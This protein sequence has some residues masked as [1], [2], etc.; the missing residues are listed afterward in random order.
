M[1]ICLGKG[2]PNFGHVGLH[3]YSINIKKMKR[4]FLP[5]L[6]VSLFSGCG[7]V[8]NAGTA[9]NYDDAYFVPSDI[10]KSQVYGK[11]DPNMFSLQNSTAM[12]ENRRTRSYGQSY[13]DR[14]RNFGGSTFTPSYRP[15]LM[16]TPFGTSM[17]YMP[18]GY[19]PY[20]MYG[21]PFAMGYGYNPYMY[22]PY[23]YDPYM[24]NPYYNPGWCYWNQY[25]SPYNQIYWGSNSIGGSSGS[26]SS[27]GGNRNAKPVPTYTYPSQRRGGYNSTLPSSGQS[28]RVGSGNT[29]SGNSS[30]STS[31]GS[32]YR[33]S[34]SNS[35]SGSSGGTYTRPSS[36]GSSSATGGGQSGSSGRRR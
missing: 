15:S 6:A 9:S 17:G 30:S 10:D 29:S 5:V 3:M 33:P 22:N 2:T 8:K 25:Y 19:N 4:I 36:S 11:T 14:M 20:D 31:S 24:Y 18:Y 28:S 34:S 32:Y 13:N 23:M 16:V 1:Y 21:N 35:S 26:G 27:W 7:T 12:S